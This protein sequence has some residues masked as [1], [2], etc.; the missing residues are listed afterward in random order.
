ME[1]IICAL[2][3][4]TSNSSDCV[5][6]SDWLMNGEFNAKNLNGYHVLTGSTV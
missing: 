6:S 4:G 3:N 1:I 2:L 5:M